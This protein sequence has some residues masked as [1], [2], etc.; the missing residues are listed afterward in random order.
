M[1]GTQTVLPNI[2]VNL[3]PFLIKVQSLNRGGHPTLRIFKFRHYQWIT[4]LQTLRLS[5]AFHLLRNVRKFSIV[6]LENS[7]LT[8]SDVL[9]ADHP[10]QSGMETQEFVELLYLHHHS[11]ILARPPKH[12]VSIPNWHLSSPEKIPF[13]IIKIFYCACCSLFS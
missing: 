3:V 11:L 12:C 13:S 1:H 2:R 9:S 5:S 4:L 7:T 8:E 6:K 10:W